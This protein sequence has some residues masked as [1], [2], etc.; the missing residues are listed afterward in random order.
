M[1]RR[2]VD[3]GQI[4]TYVKEFGL[5]PVDDMV[6]LKVSSKDVMESVLCLTKI[7]GGWFLE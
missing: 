5:C 3:R 4:G 7:S 1:V 6:L 2:R